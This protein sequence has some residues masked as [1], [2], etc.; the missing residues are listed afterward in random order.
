[1]ILCRQ[2]GVR[3]RRSTTSMALN[4]SR[5]GSRWQPLLCGLQQCAAGRP[6]TRPE[7]VALACLV[8]STGVNTRPL[9]PCRMAAGTTHDS[10]PAGWL[11]GWYSSLHRWNHGARGAYCIS[12]SQSRAAGNSFPVGKNLFQ[13]TCHSLSGPELIVNKVRGPPGQK[14]M[15]FR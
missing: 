6:L 2:C 9:Q 11:V 8:N 12:V 1:M 13:T 15:A 4:R 10:R 14:Y 5:P 3:R 7:L